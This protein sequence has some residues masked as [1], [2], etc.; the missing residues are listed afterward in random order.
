MSLPTYLQVMNECLEPIEY[1]TERAA[2]P[3]LTCGLQYSLIVSGAATMEELRKISK[4]RRLVLVTEMSKACLKTITALCNPSKERGLG[5]P[6]FPVRATP[7]DTKPNEDG[8]VVMI[9]MERIGLNSL[10][11][12]PSSL[13][14]GS[15]LPY[16]VGGADILKMGGHLMPLA[17][18]SKGKGGQMTVNFR[19]GQREFPDWKK[20]FKQ[21][22]REERRRSL[23]SFGGRGLEVT[24]TY[25]QHLLEEGLMGQEWGRQM[26]EEYVGWI[27]GEKQRR[28]P[29]KEQQRRQ[30]GKEVNRKWIQ[31]KNPRGYMGGREFQR[32]VK[33]VEFQKWVVRGQERDLV[34]TN[35]N[36]RGRN[37]LVQEV[38]ADTLREA[39][40]STLSAEASQKLK[41]LVAEAV[42]TVGVMD[43]GE[44][45]GVGTGGGVSRIIPKGTADVRFGRS[46]AALPHAR[47]FDDGYSQ[48]VGEVNNPYDQ[49]YGAYGVAADKSES[50]KKPQLGYFDEGY[51]QS[52]MEVD[53]QYQHG[54]GVYDNAVRRDGL[55]HDLGTQQNIYSAREGPVPLTGVDRA[56]SQSLRF[57][58][59]YGGS[60]NVASQ[61]EGDDLNV[62]HVYYSSSGNW[63]PKM[64]D[65]PDNYTRHVNFITQQARNEDQPSHVGQSLHTAVDQNADRYVSLRAP[66]WNS[67]G[68]NQDYI[69][70]SSPLKQL[71]GSL[72]KPP[73]TED[74]RRLDGSGF[75]Y[76]ESGPRFSRFGV[77]PHHS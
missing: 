26:E 20:D 5:N 36:L 37:A 8:Y 33:E 13:Q 46:D 22:Q 29:E 6:F 67:S 41:H 1:E 64:S 60:G 25:R 32:E 52:V 65:I 68:V 54:Y 63:E 40:I 48:R 55:Q 18:E 7:V 2:E 31:E 74:V 59:P 4:L 39:E 56:G 19:Q 75:G 30:V 27:G 21:S 66:N 77:M 42:R 62:R 23:R 49:K 76:T 73:G 50:K 3:I 72:P 69:P 24:A 70:L 15:M 44:R 17:I 47:Q 43:R 35:Q 9:L 10:P 34:G 58:A 38:I 16:N 53:S 28:W 71:A 12:S 14:I 51:S 11:K 61:M 57:S 45:H